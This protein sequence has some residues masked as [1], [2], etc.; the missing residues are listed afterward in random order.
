MGLCGMDGGLIQ[1]KKFYFDDGCDAGLVGEVVSIQPK[2]LV[3]VLDKGY[4]PV[5]STVA[6]GMDE[7]NTYNVNADVV[8]S[9][10]AIALGA[11]KLILLTDVVG[12]LRDYKDDTTLI[13]EVKVSDVPL[14]TK[15]KVISGGMIPKVDCCVEAIRN[16]VER[17]NIQD[18]RKKHSILMELLSD[19]GV[20]TMFI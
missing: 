6:Q 10:I 13:P 11:Q 17:V 19:E 9:K 7:Q 4:I 1:A 8:A 16:G 18:G 15:Q 12:V 14:L 5:I 20:G 2:I 3:D